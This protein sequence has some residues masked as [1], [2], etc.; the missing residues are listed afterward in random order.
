VIDPELVETSEGHHGARVLVG[1]GFEP[2][3]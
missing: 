1:S 3:A 2:P